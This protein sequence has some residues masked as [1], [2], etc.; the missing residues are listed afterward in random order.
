[1]REKAYTYSFAYIYDDI[2]SAVPYDLWYEYLKELITYYSR[3]PQNL[4]DLACGTGNMTIRFAREKNLN[5]D[6]LDLSS[7]MLE[8]ARKKA[9]D[10]AVDVNFIKGDLRSFQV[11]KKYDMA[12]SLFDSLNYILS[13][14]DLK[15]VF[16]NVYNALSNDGF[17]IFDMN[18]INRLMSIEPGTAVFNGQGYTCF[19][20]DVIDQENRRWQVN[21]KIYFEKDGVSPNEEFH[22]ETAYP[23]EKVISGLRESGFNNIDVYKAYTFEN[24]D[25]SDNRLYYIAFKDNINKNNSFTKNIGQKFKWRVKK[26]FV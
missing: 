25:D 3:D 15:K 17:F 7:D 10:K 13:Y 2:M 1:M 19:W 9:D 14:Q 11:D 5:C 8:I 21:L 24:G 4:L 16:N 26:I 6:G 12:F 20:E 18:T 22:Q 23:R